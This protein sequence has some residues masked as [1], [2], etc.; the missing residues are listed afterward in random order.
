MSASEKKYMVKPL[1]IDHCYFCFRLLC[2]AILV[3]WSLKEVRAETL[4]ADLSKK[5]D[6]AAILPQPWFLESQSWEEEDAATYDERRLTTY[7]LSKTRKVLEDGQK[8]SFVKSQDL[9]YSHAES[10]AAEG[11]RADGMMLASSDELRPPAGRDS[12]FT[13][14]SK[15]LTALSHQTTTP[16]F[17][18]SML[19]FGGI[20]LAS[21]IADNSL[22]KFAVNHGQNGFMTSVEKVG[23]GLPFVAIGYSAMMF[24]SSDDDSKL[25][26]TSYDSLAAGG[27]GAVSALGL[28][29]MVGRARPTAGKGSASFTPFSASNGN[30]SWP[31]MHSTVMW[32]VITPYAKAYDAPW[33][34][35]VAAVTNVARI[36]GRNHWFSDTISGSLLGYAIGNFMWE[37][38]QTEKGR[39]EWIIAPNKIA[40]NWNF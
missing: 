1:S 20:S 38:K 40:A 33:L 14:A 4:N 9:E 36:G 3:A 22:D 13:A 8:Q 34:Y 27:V 18:R 6:S 7:P 2:C 5:Y 23:N 19:V 17:W 37:S 39:A 21:A 24:L 25:A 10:F 32:A 28:K 30:T 26:Q 29:Y 16:E 15:D 35:G 31:S 11:A 12:V